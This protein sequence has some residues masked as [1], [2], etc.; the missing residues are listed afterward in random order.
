MFVDCQRSHRAGHKSQL[1]IFRREEAYE[2]SVNDAAIDPTET[3]W[4]K[5]AKASPRRR[6]VDGA[7]A[8]ALVNHSFRSGRASSPLTRIVSVG[9]IARHSRC[10]S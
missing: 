4:F 6:R 1:P 10:R 8:V 5:A 2:R 3:M 7:R 9:S